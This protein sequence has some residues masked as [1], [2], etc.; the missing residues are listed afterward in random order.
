MERRESPT[1]RGIKSTGNSYSYDKNV[2]V[3]SMTVIVIYLDPDN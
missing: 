1:E 3:E 2:S